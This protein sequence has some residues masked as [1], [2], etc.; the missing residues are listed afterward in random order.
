VAGYLLG[1]SGNTAAYL[2]FNNA[3]S[4]TFDIV[5]TNSNGMFI[6]IMSDVYGNEL[7]INT[8]T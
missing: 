7:S 6:L 5:S 8:I 4:N 1:G 2:T 3:T